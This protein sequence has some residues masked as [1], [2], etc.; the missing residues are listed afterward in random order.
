MQMAS[1][2]ALVVAD[3]EPPVG[4]RNPRKWHENW[5]CA[6]C[7]EKIEL[8][9]PIRHYI[10][11]NCE[12]TAKCHVKCFEQ[13]YDITSFKDKCVVCGFKTT[14]HKVNPGTGIISCTYLAS[15]P[16]SDHDICDLEYILEAQFNGDHGPGWWYLCVWTGFP[17]ADTWEPHV[18]MVSEEALARAA[19]ARAGVIEIVD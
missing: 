18:H 15:D 8:F 19:A 11:W 14:A 17:G 13:W 6:I 1:N 2:F 12:C 5:K 16:A 7:T 9:D 3:P 10:T 4:A